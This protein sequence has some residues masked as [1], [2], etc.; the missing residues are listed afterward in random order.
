MALE[1]Q[2]KIVLQNK[3]A[4]TN[5]K[6]AQLSPVLDIKQ[7]ELNQL[8][9]VVRSYSSD[10]TLGDPDKVMESMLGGMT[11]VVTMAN[12]V[13]AGTVVIETLVNALGEDQ[14]SL[15]PHDF[16]SSAFTIPTQCHHCKSS[17]WGL[18]KQGKTC[19]GCAIT[20]HAKCELKVGR[21]PSR[22]T[23]MSTS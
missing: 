6:V 8:E 5:I 18:S 10:P 22:C 20:V 17:I 15:Q 1:D 12:Q 2:P 16:K 23:M 14:G 3:L 11:E 13:T 9:E 19:R 7:G 21:L 4:K